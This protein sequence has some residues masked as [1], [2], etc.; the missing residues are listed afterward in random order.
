MSALPSRTSLKNPTSS[1][2][3]RT[4]L[5]KSLVPSS[6]SYVSKHSS[7][8]TNKIM[9]K[10][11]LAA[12]RARKAQEEKDRLRR[13][14]LLK[15]GPLF[16]PNF[17]SSSSSSSSSSASSSSS[18]TSSTSSSTSTR[19][20]TT[21]STSAT[22]L[23]THPTTPTPKPPIASSSTKLSSPLSRHVH[24]TPT[25]QFKPSTTSTTP[26]TPGSLYSP[27]T[28]AKDEG[29]YEIIQGDHEDDLVDQLSR[30]IPR[31]AQPDTLLLTLKKQDL[32]DPDQVFGKMTPFSLEGM[33]E[34]N[35]IYSM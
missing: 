9:I 26:T 3:E 18:S 33:K 24:V 19:P 35:K 13:Q 8:S 20:N 1:K 28:L 34:K 30:K 29:L 14:R 12:E 31:W 22:S 15:S 10:S 4:S 11:L 2:P 23:I 6:T 25:S 16:A 21:S 32:V 7:M 5:I 17:H 27:N